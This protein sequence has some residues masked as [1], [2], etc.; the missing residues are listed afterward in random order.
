[1]HGLVDLDFDPPQRRHRVLDLEA[2]RVAPARS[3]VHAFVLEREV[4]VLRLVR[5]FFFCSMPG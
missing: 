3:G 2:D 1:M 5:C 4:A